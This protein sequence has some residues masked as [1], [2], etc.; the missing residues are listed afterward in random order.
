MKLESE[1]AED[2]DSEIFRKA[3]KIFEKSP[4]FD[5]EKF[6]LDTCLAEAVE[7]RQKQSLKGIRKSE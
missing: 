4:C 6:L 2:V 7:N 1:T 3:S 5:R